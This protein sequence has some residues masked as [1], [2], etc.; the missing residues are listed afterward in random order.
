SGIANRFL[1]KQHPIG[2]PTNVWNHLSPRITA[3]QCYV[4]AVAP[5][6]RPRGR[7]SKGVDRGLSASFGNGRSRCRS[8]FLPV[9]SARRSWIVTRGAP[10]PS[11]GGSTCLSSL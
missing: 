2:G 7:L 3:F 10:S 11:I 4:C 1:S 8:P 5:R 6:P 9:G